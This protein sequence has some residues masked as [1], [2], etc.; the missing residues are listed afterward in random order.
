SGLLFEGDSFSRTFAAGETTDFFCSVHSTRMFG[1]VFV[2]GTGV[3]GTMIPANTNI[4]DQK[5]TFDIWLLNFTGAS[6]SVNGR[7][8]VKDPGGATHT[9]LDKNGNL[10]PMARL[11]VPF[12]ITLPGGAPVGDY[13]VRLE[14]RDS[15]G[16]L[17]SSDEDLYRKLSLESDAPPSHVGIIGE[18]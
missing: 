3:Q 11:H 13:T 5:I 8:R 18:A 6:Q 14:L 12:A 2:D 15:G 16:V 17:R 9:V 1:Q 7:V 10:G 4:T